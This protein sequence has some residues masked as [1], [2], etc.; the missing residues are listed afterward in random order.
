MHNTKATLDLRAMATLVILCASWGLAQVAIKFA[1]QGV[2]PVLQAGVRSLGA[3]LL[4]WVWMLIRREPLFKKDGTLW[5][6]ILIGV[7][8]SGEFLLIYWGLDF[9]SASRA[10]VFLYTMPFVVALG[11]Q[12]LIP[13]ERLRMNQVAGLCC[14]FIGVV[15]AFSEHIGLADYG[16]L[17]GDL[18]LFGAAVLW[19]SVTILIKITPLSPI[20]P[21]K[22]LFYQLAVSALV[23][24]PA[25]WAM[26]EPGI[27]SVSPMIAASI[28]YQTVWVA[29]ITYLAWFWLV[30]NYPAPRLTSFSFLTPLF[31]V[32]LGVVLLKEDLTSA[33]LLALVLVCL[34][35]YLVNRPAGTRAVGDT[36]VK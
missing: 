6:G 2:S 34:G 17:I 28:V 35:I 14:A 22:T 5:W 8:F 1:N 10:V 7:L 13:G 24:P 31:G 19:G 20:R 18:M 16:M 11:A 33:L 23:L 3:S 30:Q 12:F 4:V 32:L 9:T 26:G 25:S 15:V 27:V 21:S 29:A 36:R